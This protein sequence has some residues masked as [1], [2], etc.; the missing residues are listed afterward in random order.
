MEVSAG[1]SE[2]VTIHDEVIP[3]LRDAEWSELSWQREYPIANGQLTV[4]DGRVLRDRPLRAD[5][6]LTRGGHPIAIVECK[7]SIRD[8]RDGV[9]Q[10]RKYARYLDVPLAYATNGRKVIEIDRHNQTEREVDRFRTPDE[11]WAFFRGAELGTDAA[12]DFFSTPYSRRVTDATG[13]PKL[14]RY[15]QHVALRRLLTR[16]AAGQQRLLVVL[17]TGTGKTPLAAQLIHVL[18]QNHWPRGKGAAEDRPRVLYLADRDVLVQQPQRDWFRPIFGQDTVTRVKGSVSTAKNIYLALY[19]ALDGSS[20]DNE[21]LF[22]QFDAD[23]FDLVVVDECHRG[24]A[25]RY[26][27]WREVLDYFSSAV[28]LGMTATP[29]RKGYSDT[30]EYFGEPVYTY[31][32]HHGIENGFLAPFEVVRVHLDSDLDGVR[33]GPDVHDREGQLVPEGDYGPPQFE[34]TLVIPERTREAARFLTDFLRRNGETGKTIV[35]CHDQDHAARM[36]EELV[37]LNSDLLSRYGESG[38][39]GSPRP[40]TTGTRTWRSSK[41]WIPRCRWWRLR[42]SC[43]PREW[44]Y[45]RRAMWCCFAGSSQQWSSS[46]SSDAAP[47]WRQRWVRSTSPFWTSPGRRNG[48]PTPTSMAHQC[49]SPNRTIP[50]TVRF[51]S[52]WNMTPPKRPMLGR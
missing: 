19:Q 7:R 8:E 13:D 44:I 49:A 38:S 12:V 31:S 22:R 2:S 40:S 48:S 27:Q 3:R 43:C 21:D 42:P 24:S 37:N 45:L 30:Y 46:R 50:M 41:A 15:Y 52:R 28:Q 17:A 34:R 6:V 23:F 11:T 47:G 36:R 10:A 5:F 51:R 16:I 1:A 35:F 14:P 9:Q 33:I 39:C 32:L 29:V 4:V 25:S 18:W 26:S 20:D